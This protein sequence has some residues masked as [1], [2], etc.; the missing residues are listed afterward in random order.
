M[1]SHALNANPR[2]TI[3]YVT[4]TDYV[5]GPS[6]H[7]VAFFTYSVGDSTY[8]SSS[9]GD[10][11]EGCTR[12]L[13]KFAAADPTNKEFFNKVCVPDSI[14]RAPA[15]GWTEPPFPVPGE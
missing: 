11:A 4:G 15:L 14:A 10:L 9:D 5:V 3:G 8:H 1:S 6:S 2:Y 12:C 13:V 7:S